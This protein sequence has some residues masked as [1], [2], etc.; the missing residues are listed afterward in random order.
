MKKSY[1]LFNPG[2][3]SRKDNTLKFTPVDEEGNEGVPRYIPVEGSIICFVSDPSMQIVPCLTSWVSSKL[4][5]IF[6]IIMN[7]IQAV[8]CRKIIY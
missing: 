4:P 7:I 5:F 3:L 2:R 8:S 6:L 1:Y